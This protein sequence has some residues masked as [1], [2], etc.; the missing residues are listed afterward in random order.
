[1]LKDCLERQCWWWHCTKCWI[2]PWEYLSGAL[3]TEGNCKR[4]TDCS[5]HFTG[6]RCIKSCLYLKYIFFF[7]F[8][9][10]VKREELHLPGQEEY[11]W[12]PRFH[13]FLLWKHPLLKDWL[14]LVQSWFHIPV[15]Q[16]KWKHWSAHCNTVNKLTLS[17]FPK[18]P[19]QLL[20]L[21]N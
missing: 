8:K 21:K 1:M 18:F 3:I 7:F 15:Q 5:N 10:L 6:W 2:M 20:E 9:D 11:L 4:V 19:P 12:L 16:E 14:F 13:S 17:P